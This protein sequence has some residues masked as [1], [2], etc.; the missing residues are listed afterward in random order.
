MQSK[1]AQLV[2]GS[3]SGQSETVSEG[4]QCA[5]RASDAERETNSQSVDT[6]AS[7]TVASAASIESNLCTRKKSETTTALLHI[8]TID[9][10][11]IQSEVHAARLFPYQFID[12]I[13]LLGISIH[14]FM[15]L[16]SKL[17]FPL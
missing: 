4:V 8:E 11:T 6:T 2:S 3:M 5:S 10:L 16:C 7:S 17:F 9:D 12:I 14:Y 15:L 1:S 13:I